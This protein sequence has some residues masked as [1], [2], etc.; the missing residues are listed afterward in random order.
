MK[1]WP[2]LL[3]LLALS[4]T[5]QDLGSDCKSLQEG[6]TS[7]D[8]NKVNSSISKFIAELSYKTHTSENLTSLAQK[9]SASCSVN[10]DV[11]CYG[12]I[13]T[14]PAQSE[15]TVSFSSAGTTVT[16]VIDISESSSKEMK[17]V[18]MHD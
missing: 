17:F 18:N 8:V 11:L 4:C 16:K 14:L 13:N 5:K 10:V 1:K 9:I 7:N 15:L 12:C 3:L 6:I 2:C